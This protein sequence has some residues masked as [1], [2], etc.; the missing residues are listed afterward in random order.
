MFRFFVWFKI[1]MITVL[2]GQH[3]F[4]ISRAIAFEKHSYKPAYIHMMQPN[5]DEHQLVTNTSLPPHPEQSM[6]APLNEAE[7]EHGKCHVGDCLCCG[8]GFC[9]NILSIAYLAKTL[10]ASGEKVHPELLIQL[11]AFTN[12]G[13]HLL[14]YRPPIIG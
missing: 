13:I 2:L 6:N 1:V 4:T 10:V 5:G 9:G 7:D 12:S 14:P 11:K 8:C 3:S